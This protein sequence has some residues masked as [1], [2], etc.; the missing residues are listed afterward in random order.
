VFKI[1]TNGTSFANLHSFAATP[2]STNSDGGKPWSGV[3]IL[4]S[5]LYGTASAGG[6]WG[7]GVLIS[8]TAFQRL[9]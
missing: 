1:N 4:G 7:G 3:I 9:S 5:T 6:N 2:S 8:P